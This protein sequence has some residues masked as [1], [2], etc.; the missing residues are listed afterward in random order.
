[1][2]VRSL[3]ERWRK[4]EARL[5]D[6]HG[7]PTEKNIHDLRVATRRLLA[8]VTL[9]AALLPGKTLRRVR[10]ELRRRLGTLTTLRD[11]QVQLLEVRRLVRTYPILHSFAAALAVEERAARRA[12]VREIARDRKSR[13]DLSRVQSD[14]LTLL[15]QPGMETAWRAAAAGEA[16]AAF[17]RAVHLRMRLRE[18]DM[19]TIHR[20]RV[21]FKKFRYTS[22]ALQTLLPGMTPYRLKAMD[23]YQTAMGEVQDSDV[24]LAAVE[25]FLRRR[26]ALGASMVSVRDHCVRRRGE[27]AAAFLGRADTLFR[28]WRL[29]S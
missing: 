3:A 11:C 9:A 8:S 1:L 2:L 13:V 28:F 20:L 4:Y 29:R 25:N 27:L 7:R 10:R 17:S 6:A 19:R 21:A 26:P 14:L 16:A 24:L 22:E 18:S 5:R 15:A 23:A 12:A